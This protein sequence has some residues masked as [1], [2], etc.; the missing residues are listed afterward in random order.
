VN[1]MK[2]LGDT[3]KKT[4]EENKVIVAKGKKLGR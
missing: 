2:E 1:V 3:I 4:Y